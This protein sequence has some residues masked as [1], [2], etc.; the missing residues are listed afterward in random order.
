MNEPIETPVASKD[1]EL[2]EANY[3]IAQA[4]E[5]L[6]R[7]EEKGAFQGAKAQTFLDT[8]G[9]LNWAYKNIEA[10]MES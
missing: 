9:L 4:I 10:E 6:I 3:L 7:A 1:E 2:E 8:G 5:A